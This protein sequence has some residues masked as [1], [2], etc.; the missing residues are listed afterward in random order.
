MKGKI[1]GE[2]FAIGKR[3]KNMH[4]FPEAMQMG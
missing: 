2:V 3:K 1:G 4:I